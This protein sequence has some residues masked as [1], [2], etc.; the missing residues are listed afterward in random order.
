MTKSKQTK[1]TR[2]FKSNKRE[3][4]ATRQ[5]TKTKTEQAE[6]LS[7]SS[8]DIDLEVELKD[9]LDQLSK[10]NAESI[11]NCFQ[12][13]RTFFEE[14]HDPQDDNEEPQPDYSE[15]NDINRQFSFGNQG[16]HNGIQESELQFVPNL[17]QKL[18]NIDKSQTFTDINQT[19]LANF[20]NNKNEP[21]T[22]AEQI[23]RNQH[24][25]DNLSAINNENLQNNL[26]YALHN[27]K[28]NGYIALLLSQVLAGNPNTMNALRQNTGINNDQ[29]LQQLLVQT[30]LPQL[31]ISELNNPR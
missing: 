4:K 25:V 7:Q 22:P 5:Y 9:V 15:P 31:L 18:S 23:V 28:N 8:S 19:S 26:G 10:D 12:V 21:Q 27:D 17:Q 29:Q 2:K 30:L 3:S 16:V 6:A 13:F 1:N 14:I 11:V 20:L 24:M